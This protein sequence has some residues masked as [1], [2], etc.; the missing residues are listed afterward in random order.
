MQIWVSFYKLV[1][2]SSTFKVRA[3]FTCADSK[4][5]KR[6]S[7]CQSFWRFRNLCVQKLLIE[8]RWNW[9]LVTL[10][11]ISAYLMSEK[12]PKLPPTKSH[13]VT[14]GPLL[15]RLT[16]GQLINYVMQIWIFLDHPFYQFI[17]LFQH[18]GLFNNFVTKTGHLSTKA[19]QSFTYSRPLK[20]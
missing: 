15:E 17:R 20:S 1:S 9:L 18:Q 4:S 2:I 7:S 12:N 13:N 5:A 14:Y 3:A 16:K 6:Q 19:I 8:C 11:N 10:Y